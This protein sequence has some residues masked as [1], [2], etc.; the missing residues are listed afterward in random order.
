M[1]GRK[2]NEEK[3]H[4]IMHFIGK[5]V[6]EKMLQSEKK[7]VVL[8]VTHFVVFQYFY[9]RLIAHRRFYLLSSL[10]V[11]SLVFPSFSSFYF[12]HESLNH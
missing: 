4:I 8:S 7:S 5:Q 10:F 1:N 9:I 3:I 6:G 11:W 2:V 12:F